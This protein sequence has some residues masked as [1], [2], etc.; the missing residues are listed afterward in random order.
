MGKQFLFSLR[1]GS[2]HDI[3]PQCG[4]KTFKTYV[5]GNNHIVANKYGRCE[6]IN[7]CGYI[8]YPKMDKNDNYEPV[9]KPY[10]PPKPIEYIDKQIVELTFNNF[11]EN[12]FFMY[13]T[14]TFGRETAYQLQEKYNIGTANGGGTIFWQQDALGR[15]R[16]AKVIY[17]LPTGRRSKSMQSWFVHKK[18]R[19]DFNFQQCFFGLHLTSKDAPVALCESEKTAIM[20]SI[21]EPAYTWVASGGSSMLNAQRLGELPRLDKVY[22][23]NNQFESWERK[24]RLFEGRQMDIT[25]DRAVSDGVIPEGSDILDLVLTTKSMAI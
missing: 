16:T 11:R 14:K 18:I 3:C 20:M 15:F 6:R 24:T 9:V 19:P 23:D 25:V 8:L 10:V 7:T 2:K 13:L 21:Y 12:V 5:D 17:Y 22:P 1:K 4:R